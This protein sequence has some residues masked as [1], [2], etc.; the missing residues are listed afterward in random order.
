MTLPRRIASMN[1][2]PD[3][4]LGVELNAPIIESILFYFFFSIPR[5]IQL[6]RVPGPEWCVLRDRI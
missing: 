5:K 2:S 4:M 3:S 1:C 6:G